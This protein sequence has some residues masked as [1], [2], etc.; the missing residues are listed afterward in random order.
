MVSV[1]LSP[2]AV[3]DSGEE[4]GGGSNDL[5]IVVLVVVVILLVAVTVGVTLALGIIVYR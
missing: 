5:I 1:F 3:T 2:H 4:S